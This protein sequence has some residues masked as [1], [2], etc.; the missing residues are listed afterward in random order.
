MIPCF[1]PPISWHGIFDSFLPSKG[2]LIQ[3]FEEE[4]A[5]KFQHRFAVGFPYGR[6]ALFCLL[7]AL[8]VSGKEVIVPAYTCVVV[9]HSVVR[10]GNEPVFIDC[11]DHDC[12][13]DLIQASDA[14]NSKT[15][16]LIATSIFGSPINLDQLNN[17][18]SKYPQLI[19][20][21]DCAHSFAATW[22]DKPVQREGHAAIYGLNVSKLIS[23]VF[24]G[25]VGTDDPMLAQELI[26][27]RDKEIQRSTVW[28]DCMRRLYLLLCKAAFSRSLYRF[29]YLLKKREQ[30]ARWTK[31]YDQSC[32]SMPKDWLEQMSNFQAAIGIEQLPHFDEFI[33]HR[34]ETARY[35]RSQLESLPPWITLMPDTEGCTYSHF[36]LFSPRRGQIEAAM[37]KRGVEVGLVIDYCV[38]DFD[39][40]RVRTGAR[41]N[42]PISRRLAAQAF[43]LPIFPG[44]NRSHVIGALGDSIAEIASTIAR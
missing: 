16:A 23:S 41:Y 30:L 32:I 20:V 22:S 1:Q 18:Q 21:Q 7:R 39:A 11:C 40:Y 33:L 13:M 2:D 35:Y 25:M 38:P 3:Q 14:I 19:I 28:T 43:N 34:R 12:N 17:I 37:S 36:T 6:T 27:I 15:A 29:T 4:F 44:V 9:P 8:G 10:S 26:S 42:Y 24:G 31:Y 5:A